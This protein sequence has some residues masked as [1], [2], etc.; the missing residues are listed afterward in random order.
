[1]TAYDNLKIGDKV[2]IKHA[3]SKW[4]SDGEIVEVGYIWSNCNQVVVQKLDHS[5]RWTTNIENLA[6][7]VM[8]N[9]EAAEY[10][11]NL[12]EYMKITDKESEYK[13]LEENYEALDMA[14]KALEQESITWIVGKD[15]CQVAVRNMPIDRMQKICAI[16]G[17]EEQQPKTIQE[18]QAESEKYQKAF[19]DGYENGYA[20]ARFDYGQQPCEGMRDATKEESKSTVEY[21]DS[22]SK[23]T[24][25]LFD[26]AYEELVFVEPHKKLS[27]N[28]QP[29]E[30][31]ISRE[32]AKKSIQRKID[33]V[34]SEDGSYD[35]EKKQY[36][37]GL[38][39]AKIAINRCNLPSVTPQPKMGKWIDTGMWL[40]G[41]KHGK[42][43][44]EM[45]D[46]Y[47][48]EYCGYSQ[49]HKTNFCPNCGADMREVQTDAA[50]D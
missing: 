47:S 19:D 36:I 3:T 34:V 23:P 11:K 16:I 22:I 15:N 8:T 17:E 49:Y 39:T 42:E 18:K 41:R 44:G 1:M 14:N 35:Y 46:A 50:S 7:I 27:T 40:E 12:I 48:C 31:C 6:V 24:G 9:K 25:F 33:E 28:L 2:K 37:N 5:W 10:N 26:E 4:F 32:A 45:I 38:L 20:Q 21:I 30:D 13:F 43:H 29:C